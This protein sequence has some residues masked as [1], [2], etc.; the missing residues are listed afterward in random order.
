VAQSKK[1]NDTTIQVIAIKASNLTIQHNVAALSKKV[2]DVNRV[3][4]AITDS[5]K[6]VPLKRELRQHSQKMEEQLSQVQEINTGL[7]IAMEEYKVSESTAKNP[8]TFAV[9]PTLKDQSHIHICRRYVFG[10]SSGETSLRDTDSDVSWAGRIR[11]GV[12][13]NAGEGNAGN[14]GNA[15]NA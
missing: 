10:S 12:G 8:C 3:L 5:L 13:S 11:G 2:D 9:A 1:I 6:D 14:D 4:A 7:T 15:G